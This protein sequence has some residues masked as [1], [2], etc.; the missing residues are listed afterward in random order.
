MKQLSQKDVEFLQRLNDEETFIFSL[1]DNLVDK[2]KEEFPILATNYIL[3]VLD[4]T[5]MNIELT[6]KF[7]SDPK[8]YQ[9]LLF[10]TLEDDIILNKKGSEE[11]SLIV[12]NKGKEK[13]EERED[14]L[15]G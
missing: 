8:N 5:S 2:L 15:L 7:F 11:Y 10:S 14:Y 6:Y 9:N 1:M 12:Q 13:V 4:L 3:N